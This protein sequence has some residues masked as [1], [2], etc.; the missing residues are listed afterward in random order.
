MACLSV[1]REGTTVFVVCANPVFPLSDGRDG[2]FEFE[3]FEL[4]STSL[5]NRLRKIDSY[6]V[7][8]IPPFFG[9]LVSL[10]LCQSTHPG[11]A[12]LRDRP[13]L[14]GVIKIRGYVEPDSVKSSVPS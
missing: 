10:D 7:D 12:L 11:L 14:R 6:I 1:Q 4:D 3:V 13:T 9:E 2:A 5:K 8:N